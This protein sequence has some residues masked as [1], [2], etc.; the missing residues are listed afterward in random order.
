MSDKNNDF[1]F[2]KTPKKPCFGSIFTIAGRFFQ[3]EIFPKNLGFVTQ[4]CIR[5]RNTMARFRKKICHGWG[6]KKKK[7]DAEQCSKRFCL[8]IIDY[9]IN[10]QMSL[11]TTKII[12]NVPICTITVSSK[13]TKNSLF[14]LFYKTVCKNMYLQYFLLDDIN[15]TIITSI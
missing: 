12:S 5:S 13:S 15:S 9:F 6:S 4:N 8:K 14:R 11:S 3:K 10:K 7:K 1:I 2:A